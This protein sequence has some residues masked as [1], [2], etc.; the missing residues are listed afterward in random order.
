MDNSSSPGRKNF[1]FLRGKAR[2]TDIG[3]SFTATTTDADGNYLFE[4]L[5]PGSYTVVETQPTGPTI[6]APG[7]GYIDGLDVSG[8]N[9]GSDQSGSFAS[10]TIAGIT[11]GI[12]ED[13]TDYDFS[14]IAAAS[15]EGFVFVDANDNGILEPGEVPIPGTVVTLEGTDIFGNLVVRTA[16]TDANGF[17]YFGD[18]YA[19][20]YE[21]LEQQPDGFDD[22][23]EQ[24]GKPDSGLHF[25]KRFA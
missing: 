17:Y 5:P 11:L 12:D 8:S 24:L 4:N 18:L 7:F 3:I 21:I 9:G 15:T 10:D 2:A 16:Q 20:T 25:P 14:E 13:A 19:R 23:Q 1:P 22:G 6:S